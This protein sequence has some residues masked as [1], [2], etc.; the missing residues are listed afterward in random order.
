MNKRRTKRFAAILPLLGLGLIFLITACH[1]QETPNQPVSSIAVEARSDGI[2]LQTAWAEFLLAPNGA[3][4]ARQKIT[5]KNELPRVVRTRAAHH[6]LLA[7]QK[8]TKKNGRP[9]LAVKAQAGKRFG[10][11]RS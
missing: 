4:L 5:K 3:L 9:R 1:K 6:A 11:A 2:H 8:I 7:L 10:D